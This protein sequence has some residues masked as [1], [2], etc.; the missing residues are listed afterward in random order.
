MLTEDRPPFDHSE[1]LTNQSI[2]RLFVDVTRQNA[3]SPSL[4]R[5]FEIFQKLPLIESIEMK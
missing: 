3:H 5:C 2:V 4:R 1:I